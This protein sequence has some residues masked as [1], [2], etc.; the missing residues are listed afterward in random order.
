MHENMAAKAVLDPKRE[1]VEE[2]IFAVTFAGIHIVRGEHDPFPQC[3]VKQHEGDTVDEFELVVPQDMENAWF[4]AGG[5]PDQPQVVSENA[6]DFAKQ[7]CVAALVAAEI[8]KMDERRL[9][10]LRSVEGVAS[11]KIDGDAMIR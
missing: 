4:R 5:V 1:A 11:D 10:Q 3:A 9:M 7:R 6:S 8:E 2:G